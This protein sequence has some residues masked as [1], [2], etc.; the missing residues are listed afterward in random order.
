V[1][2]EQIDAAEVDRLEPLW[3][4]L[5]AHHQQVAPELAPYVDDAS[6]WA[7]R[8]A[9]YE[10]V[11]GGRGFAVVASDD[12]V[13]VGYMVGV[14]EPTP[15]PASFV[16]GP[17]AVELETLLVV[18]ERRGTGVGSALLDEFD[19]RV[20]DAGFADAVVGVVSGNSDAIA[21]YER[22]GFVPT[23]LTLSRFS[24]EA[25]APAARPAAPVEAVP[26]SALDRLRSLWLDLH[27]HH[28]QVAPELAPFVSDTRS[29]E[30][31]QPALVRAAE[32]DLLLRIGPSD[33]P[34]AM[35]SVGLMHDD[36][37]WTDTWVTG[38]DVADIQVLTVAPSAR[39]RG[40]GSTLLDAIDERLSSAGVRDQAVAAMVPNRD[41]IRLYER[42]GFKPTWLQLTRFAARLG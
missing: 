11:L 13:D 31:I 26:P 28:Q 32:N 23:V 4:L 5:H 34:L 12:G 38:Q 25:P 37:L 27:H 24:R 14:A 21:L 36:P 18:P 15:F 2:L 41:A 35:A 17:E 40:L 1:K 29:W 16:A 42:R 10:D 33:S 30:V 22:R 9:L 3:L 20:K 19:E 39:G 6:S 7:V 8:R